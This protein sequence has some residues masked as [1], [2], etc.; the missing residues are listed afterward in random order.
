MPALTPELLMPAI[1]F[2]GGRLPAQPARPHLKLGSYL[3][4]ARLGPAPEASDWLSQVPADAWGMCLNDQLGDCTCAG[5]AHK[6][7]GDT[8][9]NQG[10]AVA[11]TDAEVLALYEQAAGYVPGDPST[12]RGS[13]CQTVLEYWHRNGFAGEK[14]VA[15]AKVDISNRAELQQAIALFGQLYCGL[16]VPQSA[17][18]QFNAGQPWTVVPGSPLVGGHCVTVGAYNAGGLSAVTWGQIQ[19]M[20]WE[21]FAEYFAEAWVVIGPDFIN[22]RT[23]DDVQ[24]LSL[25]Q[26]GADFAALTGGTNPV[27]EPGVAP[28]HR[29]LADEMRA[30]LEEMGL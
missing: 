11:I 1:K 22:S 21:F 4:H 8:Y 10:A 3:N 25:Y 7:I 29:S 24:G 28:H 17:E 16:E 5:V 6:R 14:P 20:T 30:W 19:P 15:F 26:L 9:V 2:R 27:P 18:D 12:D 23:G 13:T